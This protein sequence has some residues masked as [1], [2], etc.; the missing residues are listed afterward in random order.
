MNSNQNILLVGYLP[1]LVS[2]VPL[3]LLSPNDWED[4]ISIIMD[5]AESNGWP[6]VRFMAYQHRISFDMNQPVLKKIFE[7]PAIKK[8]EIEEK[9]HWGAEP[10]KVFVETFR[11]PWWA[12]TSKKSVQKIKRID[13]ARLKA[14]LPPVEMKI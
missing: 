11:S 3:A 12:T 9:F 1:K 7:V 14:G 10:L 6:F 2:Q 4:Q 5:F 13:N 8:K